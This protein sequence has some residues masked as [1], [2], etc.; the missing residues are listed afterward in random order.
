MLLA[1]FC[2]L[3]C[4]VMACTLR[5]RKGSIILQNS[6]FEEEKEPIQ[7]YTH[8]LRVVFVIILPPKEEQEKIFPEIYQG[9][10]QREVFRNICTCQSLY[11]RMWDSSLVE[12]CL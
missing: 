3:E 10:S 5:L 12:I 11:V 6:N 1:I 8:M 9:Q 7:Q 4:F 2:V